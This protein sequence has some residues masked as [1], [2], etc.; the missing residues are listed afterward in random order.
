M[1]IELWTGVV[2]LERLYRPQWGTRTAEWNVRTEGWWWLV[3]LFPPADA[4]GS[5][6]KG[7]CES[8]VFTNIERVLESCTSLKYFNGLCLLLGKREV[9]R[10]G[11]E[12]GVARGI[13][14]VDDSCIYGCL[15]CVSENEAILASASWFMYTHYS[16][17]QRPVNTDY[18]FEQQ[19]LCAVDQHTIRLYK[20]CSMPMEIP[21]Q[22]DDG[23]H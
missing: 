13:G 23:K 14:N 3:C 10:R 19:W 17:A 5:R 7:W 4:A 15:E 2:K 8:W 18:I 1:H 20:V 16:C 9:C 22:Y 21:T 12:T 6:E 11:Q